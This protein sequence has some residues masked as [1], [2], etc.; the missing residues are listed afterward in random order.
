MRKLIGRILFAW[1]ILFL[2]PGAFAAAATEIK[3]PKPEIEVLPNGLTT[4]WFV[5]DQLPVVDLA[6]LVKS[7]YRDDPAGK[8]GTAEL[9]SATLDRGSRG[10]SAQQISD[11]VEMLGASRYTNSDDDTFTVGMH[12]LA[13]DA[14]ALLGL[15]AKI[16]LEP[17]FAPKEV[18]R[19]HARILDRWNHVGDYGESLAGL[20]YH[21][22]IAAGTEYGRGSFLSE[23]EF[24]N[25]TRADVIAFH[26]RHFTP[27]NSVVMVVGRVNKAEF[28]TRLQEL[29]GKWQGP[30]P[31]RALKKY[32]DPRIQAPKGQ[33]VLVGRDNL[34][35]AQVRLGFRSP[36]LKDPDHYALVVANALLGEYF[37]SRLNSLIRDK[38]G[39]TY[40]IGSSFGYS[41]DLARFTISSATRNEQV[42]ELLKKTLEVL[43]D[44][45]KGPIPDAEVNMAKEYLVG[46]FPLSVA[47]LG[48]VASRWLS[49]YIYELGPDYLNEFVPRVSAVT[50][51]QVQAAVRKHLRTQLKDLV[52][53]VA[54]EPTTVH[55]SLKSAGFAVKR[56]TVENL[57]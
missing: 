27:G 31:S 43:Q 41:R 42:G 25:V 47:T 12:G 38:L 44:L 34:T 7:G 30:A 50:P 32:S 26:R 8:S 33:V 19:E 13:P 37:N 35:Q 24:R 2:A 54:G 46:G 15:M 17:E 21:R 5:N 22:I 56:A 53:V 14:P 1:P 23:K 48:T 49:G 52:I 28:R 11:A 9:V 3:L 45:A 6:L 18:A 20:A 10:M 39:L 40:G 55:S 57:K 36:S 16:V 51:A 29:F 4:V